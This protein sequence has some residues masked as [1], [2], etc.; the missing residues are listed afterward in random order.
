[1]ATIS[2]PNIDNLMILFL[3]IHVEEKICFPWDSKYCHFEAYLFFGSHTL[4]P[5]CIRCS[6]FKVDG[7]RALEAS[8]EP[9]VRI[10]ED[11]VTALATYAMTLVPAWMP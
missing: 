6:H 3:C 8:S 1:M 2:L 5:H 4:K 7:V 11:S 10:V 9:P